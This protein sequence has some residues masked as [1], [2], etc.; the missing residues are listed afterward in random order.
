M[1]RYVIGRLFD[2]ILATGVGLA[3]FKLYEAKQRGPTLWELVQ[4]YE[5]RP[6][7]LTTL[8]Q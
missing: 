2:P 6:A 3:A 1:Y 7:H 8:I 4:T 5:A